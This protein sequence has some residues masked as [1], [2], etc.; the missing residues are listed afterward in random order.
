ML[1]ARELLL[2]ERV[3]QLGLLAQQRR[4]PQHVGLRG[5]VHRAQRR[6]EPVRTRARA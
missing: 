4:R 2:D 5:G 6:Y 3:E 1:G